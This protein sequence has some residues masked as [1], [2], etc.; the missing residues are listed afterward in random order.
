MEEQQLAQRAI[1][2]NAEERKQRQNQNTS[3]ACGPAQGGAIETT[4]GETQTRER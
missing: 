2:M 4:Q 1:A 3:R